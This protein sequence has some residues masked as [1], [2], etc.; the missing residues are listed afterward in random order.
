MRRNSIPLKSVPVGKKVIVSELRSD[1][2]ALKRMFDLGLIVG[3]EIEPLYESPSGGTRAYLIRGA[4][5][6]LRADLSGKIMVD[7]KY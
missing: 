4:V 6:A 7:Y 3:T 2:S 5:I 1:G